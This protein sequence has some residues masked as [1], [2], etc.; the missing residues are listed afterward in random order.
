MIKIELPP[1]PTPMTWEIIEKLD[2]RSNPSTERDIADGLGPGY[3]AGNFL[4]RLTDTQEKENIASMRI[5]KQIPTVRTE[6][7]KATIRAAQAV[8]PYENA[9]LIALKTLKLNC[10]AVPE[11]LGHQLMEQDEDAS[12]AGRLSSA[13]AGQ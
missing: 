9:E 2:E 3:F 1:K 11:L 5:W 8:E 7:R 12:E 13:D 6:F 10:A 4:C